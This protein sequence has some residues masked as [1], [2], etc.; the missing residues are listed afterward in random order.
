[1]IKKSNILIIGGCGFIGYHLANKLAKQENRNNIT[2]IDNLSR[3]V[4]D[5][6]IKDLVDNKKVKFLKID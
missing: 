4:F 3:G 6:N 1:M 2:I 5:N